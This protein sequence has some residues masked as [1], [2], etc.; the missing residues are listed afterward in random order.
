MSVVIK[1]NGVKRIVNAPT[2]TPLLYVLRNEMIC[3]VR[4]LFSA[5]E[6][7]KPRGCCVLPMPP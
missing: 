3:G 5:G 7:R 4:A 1:V 2:E 6:S